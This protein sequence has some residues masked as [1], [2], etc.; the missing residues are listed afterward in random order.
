MLYLSKG[1]NTLD[2]VKGKNVYYMSKVKQRLVA[3][4]LINIKA[5]ESQNSLLSS[6]HGTKMHLINLD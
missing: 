2:H 3:K 4:G 1:H 6:I 5:F